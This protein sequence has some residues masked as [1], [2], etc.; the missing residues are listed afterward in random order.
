MYGFRS[1]TG[2]GQSTYALDGALP[3]SF[4][5]VDA[6]ALPQHH[7]QLFK[8]STLPAATHTL[9]VTNSR[10]SLVLDYFLVGQSVQVETSTTVSIQPSSSTSGIYPSHTAVILTTKAT[11]I[12]PTLFQ[13]IRADFF[14]S[15]PQLLRCLRA[16]AVH[17]VW[18]PSQKLA[19][20]A[21]VTSIASS[22]NGLSKSAS[23]TIAIAI[24]VVSSAVI[25][26]IIAWIFLSRRRR[27]RGHAEAMSSTVCF[28]VIIINH[29]W[30]SLTSKTSPQLFPPN[31]R[32]SHTHH[33]THLFRKKS[34]WNVFPT[35]ALR[36][37][38]FR[39]MATHPATR[40][41]RL[42]VT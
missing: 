37:S 4:S 27:R 21:D 34:V 29:P 11:A 33:S 22:S 20:T 31:L 30:W 18:T 28:T 6:H 7:I 13:H 36:G 41:S 2:T 5:E 39:P 35:W 1:Q 12:C 32:V 14:I 42:G 23:A 16:Q 38:L 9:V 25:C 26:G 8:S 15:R 3:F 10:G 24:V 17:K 19:A 40:R